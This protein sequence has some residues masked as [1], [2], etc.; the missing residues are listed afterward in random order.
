[1]EIRWCNAYLAEEVNYIRE[2]AQRGIMEWSG[3]RFSIEFN[4]SSAE[5]NTQT[6]FRKI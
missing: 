6:K 3:H 2:L 4:G 1:M 5:P